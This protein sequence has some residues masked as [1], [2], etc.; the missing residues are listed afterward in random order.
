MGRPEEYWLVARA[1]ARDRRRVDSLARRP[2]AH[3]QHSRGRDLDAML[4][5]VE[6]AGGKVVVPTMPIAGVGW[7]AFCTDRAGVSL[8]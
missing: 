8:A 4:Q 6:S 5:S 7:L 3:R 2:A 1:K